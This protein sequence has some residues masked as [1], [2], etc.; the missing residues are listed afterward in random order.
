M[1]PDMVLNI[2]TSQ[3]LVS[4]GAMNALYISTPRNFATQMVGRA[5]RGDPLTG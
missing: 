4:Q 2:G 3:L 5:G 1:Y